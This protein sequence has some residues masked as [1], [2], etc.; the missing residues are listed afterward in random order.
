MKKL[1]QLGKKFIKEL[2]ENATKCFAKLE[3][4]ISNIDYNTKKNGTICIPSY[5]LKKKTQLSFSFILSEPN[6]DLLLK[7]AAKTAMRKIKVLKNKKII[8]YE[9]PIPPGLKG[10]IVNANNMS[11]RI[12]I[13]HD[14]RRNLHLARID[15]LFRLTM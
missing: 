3:K 10:I 7:N 14:I 4:I 12:I 11:V 13:D 8:F 15:I 5:G 9:L 1:E 6:I 2:R